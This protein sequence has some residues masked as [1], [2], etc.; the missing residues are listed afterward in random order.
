M[1]TPMTFIIEVLKEFNPEVESVKQSSMDMETY[2]A[3]C[4]DWEDSIY[5]EEYSE[6]MI[7]RIHELQHQVKNHERKMM[8]HDESIEEYKKMKR[9]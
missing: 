4:N 6:D 8:E 2:I 7:Y 5:K 1:A 3:T 9:K